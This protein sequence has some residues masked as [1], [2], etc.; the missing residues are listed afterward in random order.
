VSSTASYK[1]PELWTKEGSAL[2]LKDYKFAYGNKMSDSE[3]APFSL[4]SEG[5]VVNTRGGSVSAKKKSK[6]TGAYEDMPMAAM[7]PMGG[8]AIE[9]MSMRHSDYY[10]NPYDPYQH[11]PEKEDY[12]PTYYKSASDSNGFYSYY[13]R[14]ESTEYVSNKYDG[15]SYSSVYNAQTGATC[16]T[17][18][19][20]KYWAA[21]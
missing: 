20:Q 3:D 15:T 9:S 19:Y 21:Y 11:K 13:T 16:I 7:A 6:S 8:A 4:S 17:K 18:T 2:K 1:E 10:Y 5:N 12:Q 14:G